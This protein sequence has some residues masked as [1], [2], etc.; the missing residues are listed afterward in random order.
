MSTAFLH[1]VLGA[2]AVYMWP[3][4]GYYTEENILWKPRKA[5]HGLRKRPKEWQEHLAEVLKDLGL[6]RLVSK[7]NVYKNAL[8]ALFLLAHVDDLLFFGVDT[9]VTRIFKAIQAQVLVRPTGELLVGHTIA[10]LGRQ[11]T[12]KGEYIEITL[13]DKYMN[14]STL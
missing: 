10:F 7:P 3:P 13:G 11:L 6:Q 12:H 9:E 5:M 4:A 2:L 8:G 14:T 1:A